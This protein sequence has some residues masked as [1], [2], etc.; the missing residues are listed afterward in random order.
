MTRRAALGLAFVTLAGGVFGCSKTDD[1]WKAEE[2]G[3]LN[4]LAQRG[5]R[6]GDTVMPADRWARRDGW[7]QLQLAGPSFPAAKI[8][9]IAQ[10]GST[11]RVTVDSGRSGVQT[12]DVELAQFR[13]S[14]GDTESESIEEVVVS[15]GGDT[16]PAEQA[17]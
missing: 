5:A 11:L 16:S 7:I 2:D 10:E 15:R 17:D 14:G 13:L 1:V 3:S 4:V 6:S 9:G 8:K 12:L